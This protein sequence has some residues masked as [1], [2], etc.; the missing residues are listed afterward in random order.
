MRERGVDHVVP[1]RVVSWARGDDVARLV[2][3]SLPFVA[4]PECRSVS[5]GLFIYP[6]THGGPIC[7]VLG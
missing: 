2:E 4:E 7:V 6:C 5:H 3:Q 1:R